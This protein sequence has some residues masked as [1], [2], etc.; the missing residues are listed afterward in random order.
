MYRILPG[1][2]DTPFHSN[3]QDGV[4]LSHNWPLLGLDRQ[5]WRGQKVKKFQTEIP[6]KPFEVRQKKFD[7][8]ISIS[9]EIGIRLIK[10]NF[11]NDLYE[12]EHIALLSLI[13]M[14]DIEGILQFIEQQRYD[15]GNDIESITFLVDDSNPKEHVTFTR[16]GV[17]ISDIDDEQELEDMLSSLPIGVLSGTYLP[18]LEE[19]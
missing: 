1:Y 3:E 12:E 4:F 8:L 2:K 10:I 6:V 15:F 5:I 16:E 11:S 7:L 17:L 18:N 13:R 14:S 19:L 9:K